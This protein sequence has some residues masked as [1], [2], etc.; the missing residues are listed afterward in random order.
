MLKSHLVQT[1]K[2]SIKNGGGG[3][4]SDVEVAQIIYKLVA[5]N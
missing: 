1:D 4:I 2:Q 5:N 3:K